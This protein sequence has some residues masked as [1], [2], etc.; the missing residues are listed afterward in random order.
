MK[1]IELCLNRFDVDTK[2]AFMELYKKVDETV[3]PQP[4]SEPEA[5]KTGD[6]VAF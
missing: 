1:A 5:T 3:D 2:N 6:E 4:V